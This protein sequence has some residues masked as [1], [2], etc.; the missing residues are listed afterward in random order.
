[1]ARRPEAI[2]LAIAIRPN[3]DFGE[4]EEI[5]AQ[6]PEWEDLSVVNISA[7]RAQKRFFDYAN[8]TSNLSN[9]LANLF[10]DARKAFRNNSRQGFSDDHIEDE[11]SV[12]NFADAVSSLIKVR[13][14]LM[15]FVNFAGKRE[16]SQIFAKDSLFFS[17]HFKFL[18]GG[19][20]DNG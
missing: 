8:D 19:S 9:P 12:D 13:R 15:A 14:D 2:E 6:E 16:W 11:L 5:D 1:M 4:L 3:I 7:E 20:N 17:Q 10:A 18:Y